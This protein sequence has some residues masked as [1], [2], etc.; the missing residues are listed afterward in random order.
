MESRGQ[1]RIILL[2]VSIAG[3]VLLG[4][5]KIEDSIFAG[6]SSS[7]GTTK[8]LAETGLEGSFF[9]FLLL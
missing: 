4:N 8:C 6:S 9:P 2:L 1:R 3:E 7:I 5:V